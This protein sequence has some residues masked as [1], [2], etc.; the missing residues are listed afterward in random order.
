MDMTKPTLARIRYER[1]L[2]DIL[3]SYDYD[4]SNLVADGIHLISPNDSDNDVIQKL[5]Q[6]QELCGVCGVTPDDELNQQTL[7]LLRTFGFGDNEPKKK[8]NVYLG[9]RQRKNAFALL[10]TWEEAICRVG[11]SKLAHEGIYEI[12]AGEEIQSAVLELAQVL[13]LEQPRLS[14]DQQ[15]WQEQ[16]GT[17]ISQECDNAKLDFQTDERVDKKSTRRA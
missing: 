5:Q 14:A 3:F 10:T 1:P 15:S 13:D 11:L 12:K 9:M 4:E 6:M 17:R 2:A 8:L 7:V 16:I